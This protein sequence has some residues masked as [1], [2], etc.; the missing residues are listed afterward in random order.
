M[1]SHAPF[2]V[3]FPEGSDPPPDIEA[4]F[5]AIVSNTAPYAFFGPRPLTVTHHAGLDREL[6]LTLFRKP[7]VGVLLPAAASAM[8]RGRRLENDED[9]AQYENL[10]ELTL[11]AT[12]GPFPWQVDGDYLGEVERLEVRYEPDSLT[13]L[14][15]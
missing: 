6:A 10:T 3:E 8:S 1:V 9:I 15:P 2:R 13:L 14:V 11:V 4:G 7:E 5:F 12:A